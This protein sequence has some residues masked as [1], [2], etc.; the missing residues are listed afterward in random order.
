M[1]IEKTLA[2]GTSPTVLLPIVSMMIFLIQSQPA[3]GWASDWGSGRA[4]RSTD[5][6]TMH[7]WQTAI[8]ASGVR[9]FH[10]TAADTGYPK[11]SSPPRETSNDNGTVPETNVAAHPPLGDDGEIHNEKQEVDN[12]RGASESATYLAALGW[13]AL[14]HHKYREAESSFSRALQ[15]RIRSAGS[16]NYF[17]LESVLPLAVTLDGEGKYE[18]AERL[19]QRAMPLLQKAVIH[20]TIERDTSLLVR[21]LADNLIELDIMPMALAR[22]EKDETPQLLA[23]STRPSIKVLLQMLSMS[24][25]AENPHL[26][27]RVLSIPEDV[28]DALRPDQVMALINLARS[29]GTSSN[30]LQKLEV[31][32]EKLYRLAVDIAER[33]YGVEDDRLIPPLLAL[34]IFQIDRGNLTQAEIT[35]KRAVSVG[36]SDGRSAHTELIDA[37]DVLS[38]IYCRQARYKDS[39]A[40]SD[41]ILKHGETVLG[42]SNVEFGRLL[43]KRATLETAAEDYAAAERFCDQAEN[44]IAQA[45]GRDHAEVAWVMRVH[46]R[47]LQ[48]QVAHPPLLLAANDFLVQTL[49]LRFLE[50]SARSELARVADLEASSRPMAETYGMIP[51]AVDSRSALAVGLAVNLARLMV[52]AGLIAVIM[53]FTPIAQ[54]IGKT[55]LCS[56]IGAVA[57]VFGLVFGLVAC[58][59]AQTLSDQ[60]PDEFYFQ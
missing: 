18:Q 15:L 14:R 3:W 53:S 12:G 51:T 43:L 52:F 16:D 50:N 19:Y 46:A 1:K 29:Y 58:L 47:I 24:D 17:M 26:A 41:K 10:D 32:Q 20:S 54:R 60:Q 36:E 2:K 6:G 40:L 27:K 8:A 25:M 34:A 30:C 57:V 9:G 33:I 38:G 31:E 4:E 23:I 13:V 49:P 35:C 5:G 55:K 42:G 28:Q 39:R 21:H 56:I 22:R 45:L 59:E 11:V 37:L 48:K 7:N 44:V